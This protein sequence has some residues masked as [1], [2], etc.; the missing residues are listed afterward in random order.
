MGAIKERR[1]SSLALLAPTAL[2]KRQRTS[3]AP[4]VKPPAAEAPPKAPEPVADPARVAA[5]ARYNSL[6]EKAKQAQRATRSA[7][8]SKF[9]EDQDDATGG[10]QSGG[11]AQKTVDHHLGVMV[12]TMK[13]GAVFGEQSFLARTTSQASIRTVGYCDI[14]SLHRTH[15]ESVFRTDPELREQ[16]SQ[17]RD[18]QREQYLKKNMEAK[19]KVDARKHGTTNGKHRSSFSSTFN[20]GPSGAAGGAGAGRKESKGKLTTTSCISTFM[21]QPK[22][23]CCSGFARKEPR[24]PRRSHAPS[25]P[26]PQRV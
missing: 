10:A 7:F 18:K 23:S 2:L 16:V 21:R 4:T 11:S 3:F 26:P 22:P 6:V 15:M 17:F 14:M 8:R 24:L 5:R 1:N 13:E 19:E 9:E 12:A 25:G 20:L